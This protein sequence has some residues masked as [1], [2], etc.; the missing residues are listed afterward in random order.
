MIG[1]K[2]ETI[3]SGNVIFIITY[4]DGQVSLVKVLKDGKSAGCYERAD[5]MPQEDKNKLFFARVTNA[6]LA[7]WNNTTSSQK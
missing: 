4:I 2:T 5:D 1:V 6:V 7:R 3:L